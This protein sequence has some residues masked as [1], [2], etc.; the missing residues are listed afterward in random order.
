MGC[1]MYR[2][3]VFPDRRTEFELY[4]WMEYE[5]KVPVR[6]ASNPKKWGVLIRNLRPGSIQFSNMFEDGVRTL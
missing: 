6:S 5:P 2:T 4:L 1:V 3:S